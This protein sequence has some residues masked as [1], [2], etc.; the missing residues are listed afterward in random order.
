M[1]AASQATTMKDTLFN[2]NYLML[3]RW[4]RQCKEDINIFSG[5]NSFV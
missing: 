4:L 3:H 1:S 2:K 5:D